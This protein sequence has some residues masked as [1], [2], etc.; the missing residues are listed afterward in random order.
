MLATDREGAPAPSSIGSETD[1]FHVDTGQTT[2][3]DDYPTD[4]DQFADGS[5]V[6]TGEVRSELRALLAADES[7]LGQV[8]RLLE[9]GLGADAV[10]EQ[11]G[12]GTSSFVWNYRRTIR[13]LL[14]NDLPV[15]P[16]VALLPR[17]PSG[18]S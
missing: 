7:R 1:H 10:A 13:A 6:P 18:H 9:Q 2:G 3:M 5:A 14:D 17:A 4:A 12:V 11:L 8:Y 15:A 16:T